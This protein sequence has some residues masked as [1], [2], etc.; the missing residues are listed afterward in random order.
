MNKNITLINPYV[1]ENFFDKNDFAT[2]AEM[3]TAYEKFVSENS[4]VIY[5]INEMLETGDLEPINEAKL[6]KNRSNVN[7][8]GTLSEDPYFA[9]DKPFPANNKKSKSLTADIDKVI[10]TGRNTTIVTKQQPP[11]TNTDIKVV[12]NIAFDSTSIND[13]HYCVQLIYKKLLNDKNNYKSVTPLSLLDTEAVTEMDALFAFMDIPNVDISTF[14]TSNV[15]NME[16]MFYK[17]SFNNDSIKN[18]DVS[19]VTNMRN[20]FIGSDMTNPDYISSWYPNTK[21]HALPKLG[22][23]ANDDLDSDTVIDKIFGNETEIQNKFKERMK[24][25][26]NESCH[27][28]RSSEFIIEGHYTDFIKN[29]SRQIKS[30]I[31]ELSTKLKNGMTY[32][33]DKFGNILNVITAQASEK[34]VKENIVNGVCTGAQLKNKLGTY[35]TIKQSDIEYDNYI[36]FLNYS[37]TF[38]N[39]VNEARVSMSANVSKKDGAPAPNID[40]PD[41]NSSQLEHYLRKTVTLRQNN[42]GR[43][44]N[45]LVVWGAP[46]IGK[47]SIPKAIIKALNNEESRM[48]E[49]R[50]MTV[51]V[52][53]CSQM[54]ADGFALPTPAKQQNIET[55]VASNKEATRLASKYKM[56]AD[57]LQSIEYKVS[58]DAPKTWLPVYKPTGD[59]KKDEILNALANGAVQPIYDE[60]G[61]VTGYEKTGSGG[62][63]L[64]DEFLRANQQIFFIVCQLMF[65]G[66][67]GEYV[68]GNKWQIVAAS[69]RPS[70]DKEVR[71]KYTDA[72]AAGFNRLARCNFV[73]SFNEWK[74]WA[75]SNGFDETTLAFIAGKPLDGHDSRWHNFDPELKNN[76][77]A[78][79]FASPRSWSDAIKEL[80]DECA[81]SGY[82]TYSDIPRTLFQN[83]V[84]MHLPS[85]LAQE[86]TDYY[87][88]NSNTANPYTY[89]NIINNPTLTVKNKTMYKCANVCDNLVSTVQLRYNANAVIPPEEFEQLMS[90]LCRN[91]PG[92]PNVIFSNFYQK[93]FDICN[94]EAPAENPTAAETALENSYDGVG[95]IFQKTFPDFVEQ[96]AQD[97][98]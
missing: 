39:K 55:L 32:I 78:P 75:K 92:D 43:P 40:A 36:R 30:T 94:L 62:I 79:A 82:A 21:N 11:V 16:G 14:D 19:N 42:P 20:M 84:E 91:Y 7:L 68:L 59:R 33:F 72:A 22:I 9:E 44:Q 97:N 53:D 18:W 81:Y 63:L 24:Y 49:S 4:E 96:L 3:K 71:K 38:A 48:D 89:D 31:K 8:D 29:K 41:W 50:K 90:F 47:S 76:Q 60:D 87:F 83:L 74:L 88:I 37:S 67:Y 27:V 95:A 15:T 56:D 35:D 34:Y 54:T 85:K 77:N 17:S 28:M 51:L 52:A 23:D 86:Y 46:G 13:I 73:P 2:V 12:R 61:Y 45:P 58:D 98:Y 5:K 26:A 66:R 69:N 1:W 25:N 80:Q 10:N 70:D 65:E 93:I 6:G 57:E 64:I